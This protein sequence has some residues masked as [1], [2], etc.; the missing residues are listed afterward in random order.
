[1][2]KVSLPTDRYILQCIY[3]MYAAEYPGDMGA[4]GKR[5]NEPYVPIDI[6]S[7]AKRVGMSPELLF[8]RLYYHLDQKHRYTQDNGALVSLFTIKVGDKRHAVQFPYLASILAS[9]NQEFRRFL[10]GPSI[11]VFA[12]GISLASLFIA[13]SK[14][15]NIP[16][17]NSALRATAVKT[18]QETKPR[19][20]TTLPSPPLAR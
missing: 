18:D 19:S 14:D 12:T 7:V 17:E 15:V 3:D 10:L 5:V 13:V 8:G 16:R 2:P 1:M 20:D 11:A 6:R 9:Q 4:N